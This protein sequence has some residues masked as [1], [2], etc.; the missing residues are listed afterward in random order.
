VAPDVA[1]VDLARRRTIDVRA[2]G[3][4]SGFI[5]AHQV[6]I[7][8]AH[9]SSL[10]TA[11]AVS[12][13]PPYPAVV[14][15]DHCGFQET[16][17]RSV[18]LY[19]AAVSRVSGV[20]SVNELL[21]NWARTELGV[22]ADRVW[23]VPNF[24]P[25]DRPADTVPPR[26]PGL[27]GTRVVCVANLRPQKGHVHLIRAFAQVVE[28][29][30]QAHLLLVGREAD[31]TCAELVRTEIKAHDLGARVTMLGE[32]ADVAAILHQ[33]DV[34]VLSSIGEGF[35]LALVE[36]GQAGLAVVATDVGQCAEVLDWGKAGTLVASGDP[37][38]LAAALRDALRS[39]Q[40]GKRAGQ[41][42]SQRVRE[43]YA[44]GAVIQQISRVYDTV[45]QRSLSHA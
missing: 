23:Y 28:E 25:E 40:Q 6:R 31:R 30:P 11:L 21:A 29:F 16:A 32:R 38:A 36:Y 33:C 45:A 18:S 17:P 35:P 5:R 41:R 2:L 24:V 20:I 12:Y 42:L 39:P 8:H 26:L 43:R 1:R 13:L 22:R 10:F 3:K 27:P 34:G 15:H 44:A 7:L 19:R 4:L 9:G 37:A 14:W